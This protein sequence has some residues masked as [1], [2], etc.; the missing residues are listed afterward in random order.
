MFV[1]PSANSRKLLACE[2]IDNSAAAERGRHLHE[3]LLV[4][5]HPTD[6]RRITTKRVRT[7]R[8]HET[9]RGVGRH[10]GDE[11]AFVRDIERIQT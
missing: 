10:D 3:A 6:D 5:G 1:R 7:H 2:P 4:I 9:I 11:L 8:S